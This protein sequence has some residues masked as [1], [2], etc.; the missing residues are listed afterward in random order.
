V[1]SLHE[2]LSSLGNAQLPK[3]GV[4]LTFDDGYADNFWNAKPLLEKYEVPA[5]VF[6]SSG[7]LDSPTEFW[8]DNL[9]RAL[10]MPKKLPK[11]LQLSVQ[12]RLYEW[13]TKNSDQ[14]QQ[15]YMAIHQILQPLSTSDRD[16]VMT[17][18]FAWADVDQTGRPDYRPLTSAELIELAQ[19]EFIDIGAH[20]VTHP[21]LSVMSRADQSAEI[22]GSRQKL[23]AILGS[24]V[25]TFAY[26]Y[27]N[28][29]AE[30]VDI[31]KAA[32]FKM[33]LT[34]KTNVVEKGAN[35]FQLGRF[36]VGD[37]EG[38]KFRQQQFCLFRSCSWH[39]L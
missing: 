22:V 2:L 29:T 23:T 1:L 27:G 3:Q 7:S 11:S 12:G 20:T 34:C 16:Q 14:R 28:F 19:S 8:W 18:L 21:L 35:Q 25:D 4:V 5:T 10:L 32:G 37:W 13:P 17:Q 9:E 38:E 26:S 36:G 15:V 31:V 6:I 33:A 30:T 39:P 24:Q